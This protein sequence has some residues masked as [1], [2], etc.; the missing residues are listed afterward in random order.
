M[1]KIIKN[2]KNDFVINLILEDTLD[3]LEVRSPTTHELLGIKD[4][5]RR[6][7]KIMAMLEDYYDDEEANTETD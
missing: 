1:Y 6:K 3:R 7:A 4:N 2:W 5:E